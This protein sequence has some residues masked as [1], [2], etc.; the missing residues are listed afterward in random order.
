MCSGLGTK[1]RAGAGAGK[2]A[3]GL[4][5]LWLE[6]RQAQEQG[7]GKGDLKWTLSRVATQSQIRIRTD[8][9]NVIFALYRLETPFKLVG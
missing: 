7:C 2:A 8:S 6:G 5:G 3:G 4:Q 1:L 9:E